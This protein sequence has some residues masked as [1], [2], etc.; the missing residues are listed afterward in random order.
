MI[1]QNQNGSY[2]KVLLINSQDCRNIF[3]SYICQTCGQVYLSK[4]GASE[5]KC[6]L[7]MIQK[8]ATEKENHH[9][10]AI[11]Y[12]LRYICTANLPLNSTKNK[13]FRLMFKELDPTFEIP[14]YSKLVNSMHELADSIRS[15]MLNE[16]KF[17]KVS[18]LFDTCSRWGKHYQGIVIYT[19][20]RLYLYSIMATENSTSSIE[21]LVF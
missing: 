9:K 7:Y 6:K 12:L 11:E 2:F 15:N 10:K 21:L 17:K 8:W 1:Y 13:F 16:I 18:I 5:H 4:T 14:S 19:I 20:Q 3:V